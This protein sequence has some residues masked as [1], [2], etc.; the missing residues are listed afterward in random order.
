[1]ST[2]V[3]IA[4]SKT[5][6]NMLLLFSS[7]K[8]TLCQPLPL[9]TLLYAEKGFFVL[10]LDEE[11]VSKTFC[12]F[13]QTVSLYSEGFKVIGVSCASLHAKRCG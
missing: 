9:Y 12:T 7:N 3:R 8:L 5:K 13:F 10:P 11:M 2:L 1:M 4:L 6:I